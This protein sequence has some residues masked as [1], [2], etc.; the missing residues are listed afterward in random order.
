[1]F[2]WFCG[3]TVTGDEENETTTALANAIAL[4]YPQ[5]NFYWFSMDFV[6]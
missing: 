1:M 3:A 2:C 4:I 5:I 6:V